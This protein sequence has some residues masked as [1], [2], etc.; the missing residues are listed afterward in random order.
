MDATE[1]ET[2]VRSVPGVVTLYEPDAAASR[3]AR[4]LLPGSPSLIDIGGSSEEPTI[5]VSVGVDGSLQVP[6]TAARVAEAIRAA[7]PA[8]VDADITVRISRVVR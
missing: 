8:G 6:V 5:T 2:V 1:L 3:I 4:Q 7:L